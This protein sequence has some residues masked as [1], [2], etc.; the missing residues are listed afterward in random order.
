MR[1]DTPVYNVGP[2]AIENSP[3]V[4]RTTM[5]VFSIFSFLRERER[6]FLDRSLHDLLQAPRASSS[7]TMLISMGSGSFDTRCTD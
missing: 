7:A 3:T 1:C 5:K 6:R 2:R 4:D